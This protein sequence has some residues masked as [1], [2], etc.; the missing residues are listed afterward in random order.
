M[1]HNRYFRFE[2]LSRKVQE[3]AGGETVSV[4]DVGGGDGELA[5]F[6]PQVGY[7]LAEPGVNGIS[8]ESLPSSVVRSIMDSASRRPNSFALVLM[9]RLVNEAALWSA[10]TRSTVIDF[11]PNHSACAVSTAPR[12]HDADRVKP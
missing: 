12:G 4:L 10:I 7:F 11:M 2:T 8:G 5:Q 1:N 3:L 9:D 6:L